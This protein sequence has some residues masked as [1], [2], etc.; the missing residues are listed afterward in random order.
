MTW[1]SLIRPGSR[2][3]AAAVLLI[4]AQTVA[5]ARQGAARPDS[6][7]SLYDDPSPYLD[8]VFSP[9]PAP[10]AAPGEPPAPLSL[11]APEPMELV[12]GG[13]EFSI[14]LALGFLWPRNADTHSVFG[15]LDLRYFLSDWLALKFAASMYRA[16]FEHNSIVVRQFPFQLSAVVYPL[17]TI[18][19]KPY[20]IAG[21][22]WY[23]ST[24]DYRNVFSDQFRDSTSMTIGAHGGVGV[25]W[26]HNSASIFVEG[27]YIYVDP[28]LDGL[29]SRDFDC[30][31]LL[32]GLNLLF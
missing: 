26:V 10:E 32:I 3:A 28:K 29:S 8:R 2:L 7:P 1:N 4:L 25:E 27:T 31:K 13:V 6:A 21:A 18:E 19:V 16:T 11:A 14:G 22:G 23:Y 5:E 17:P 24:V 20:V 15:E 12:G 9:V 30:W